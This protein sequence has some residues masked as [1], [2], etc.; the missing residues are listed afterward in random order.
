M[1][2]HIITSTLEH[3]TVKTTNNIVITGP[4]KGM[5][6]HSYISSRHMLSEQQNTT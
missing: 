6:T 1:R 2:I 3:V 4:P 5:Y